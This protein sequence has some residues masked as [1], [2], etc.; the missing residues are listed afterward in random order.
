MPSY[1]KLAASEYLVVDYVSVSQ[2]WRQYQDFGDDGSLR[3]AAEL[4]CVTF[5]RLSGDKEF[6]AAAIETVRE[7]EE[8]RA[9]VQEVLANLRKFREI[10]EEVLRG[11]G[12]PPE[13][14]SQLASELV[15]AIR[16]ANGFPS[17]DAIANLQGRV[18]ALGTQICEVTRPHDAHPH[19]WRH[20]IVKGMQLLGGA[21]AAVADAVT[22]PAFGITLVSI[23][24]GLLVMGADVIDD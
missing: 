6:W 9:A 21:A 19:R 2:L 14:A 20:R 24:G 23:G 1:D 10:E 7:G 16:L 13:Q 3:R 12:I 11:S 17:G 4:M 22:S 8:N 5:G 18:E 15:T